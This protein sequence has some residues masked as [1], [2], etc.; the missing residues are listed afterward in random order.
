M[1]EEV[2]DKVLRDAGCNDMVELK[3]PHN[4]VTG[5]IAEYQA[6]EWDGANASAVM[7]Y[8]LRT[9]LDPPYLK[10]IEARQ[11]A[12]Q[13]QQEAV[14]ARALSGFLGMEGLPGFLPPDFTP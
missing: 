4:I 7:A 8:M 9:I 13:A 12:A 11:A 14:N 3:I 1:T 10:A 5:F 6:A 2:P